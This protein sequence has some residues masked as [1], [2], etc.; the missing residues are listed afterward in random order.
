MLDC[1]VVVVYGLVYKRGCAPRVSI[2]GVR[3][4]YRSREQ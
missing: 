2:S 3:G 4:G 1:I